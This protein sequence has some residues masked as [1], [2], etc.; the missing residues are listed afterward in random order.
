MKR[1]PNC[2]QMFPDNAPAQCPY[3]GTYLVADAPS[4]QP[5]YGSDQP[6]YGQPVDPSA[7]PGGYAFANQYNSSAPAG[8]GGLSNIALL[9]GIIAVASLVLGF[10]LS[11]SAGSSY[12][13][14]NLTTI[15]LVSVLFLLMFITG[16]TAVNLGLVGVALASQNA[17]GRAKSIVGLCLGAVPFVLLI[18]IFMASGPRLRF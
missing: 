4:Q 12:Y 14:P 5:Y 18:V 13:G 3:D 15:K 10:L 17:T 7:Q 6:P 11:A 1:C 16:L 2:Q 9:M 8:A